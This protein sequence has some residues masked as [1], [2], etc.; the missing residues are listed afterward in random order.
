ML[1]AALANTAKPADFVTLANAFAHRGAGTGAISPPRGS[2]DNVGVTESFVTGNDVAL[3]SATLDDDVASCDHDHVLDN[4]ETGNLTVKMQNVGINTLTAATVKLSSSNPNVAFPS[5]TMVT[6][7]ASAPFA[8][9]TAKVPVTLT[10]ATGFTTFDIKVDLDGPNLVPTAGPRTQTLTFYGN[11]DWTASSSA[12]DNSDAPTTIWTTTHDAALA[13]SPTDW[14]R[15]APA[16]GFGQLWFGQDVGATADLSLVSPPL[17]VGT[18]AF[19]FT[20]K[21]HYSMEQDAST[22]PP[23]YYDGGVLELSTNGGTSWTDIGTSITTNGYTAAATMFTDA[24]DNNPLAGRPGFLG[25]SAGYPADITSTVNLGTTYAGQTIQIRFRIGTD[26]G[27]SAVGWFV[28]DSG[29][30]RADRHAVHLARGPERELRPPGRQRRAESDGRRGNDR[31]SRW[32]REHRRRRQDGALSLDPDHGSDGGAVER[33]G[34]PADVHGARPERRRH[35]HLP[36]HRRRR[37]AH[38]RTIVGDHHRDPRGDPGG[39]GFRR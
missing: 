23:T 21:H 11:Y 15:Q 18:G 24:T 3:V 2:T 13:G 39:Y 26:L 10:G 7:A 28:D 8:M 36:A 27:G 16:M 19:S 33:D 25:D 32:H 1:A 20:F 34:G 37:D 22:T 17:H 4:G 9:A 35:A 30:H 5:G 12:T 6:F 14:A 31:D 29:L 38:E